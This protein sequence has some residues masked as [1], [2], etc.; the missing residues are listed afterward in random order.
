MRKNQ[1][2][3]RNILISDLHEMIRVLRIEI[4]EKTRCA[5]C[6]YCPYDD[7]EYN[8]KHKS[9]K[10]GETNMDATCNDCISYTHPDGCVEGNAARDGSEACSKFKWRCQPTYE[11]IEPTLRLKLSE[12]RGDGK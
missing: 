3:K 5:R 2:D 7:C 8:P 10:R 12:K 11:C 1:M 6:P 4:K 9:Q